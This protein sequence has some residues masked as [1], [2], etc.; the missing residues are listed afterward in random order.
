MAFKSTYTRLGGFYESINHAIHEMDRM[1]RRIIGEDIELETRLSRDLSPVEV[2]VA[3]LEQVIMNLAV[4]ARDAMPRGGKLTIE[5]KNVALDEDYARRHI[6]TVSGSYVMLA[7]SDTGMGMTKEIQAQ[8]FE[9][10]YTTKEKGKGTGLGLSTVYGI[11]KQSRGNIWVYSEPGQGTTFKIYLPVVG[12][13]LSETKNPTKG[14]TKDLFGSEAVL[15]VEDDESLRKLAIKTLEKYGYTVLPA[16]DGREALRLCEE[17][18][19][20]IHLMVTDVIMPGMSGKDLANRLKDMMPDLRVLYMSGY[21]DNA[22]VHHGILEKGI[23]FLQKPFTP[24]GLARKVREA[25]ETGK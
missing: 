7:V 22:I 2:D 16:A 14:E 19:D 10:F 6:A 8:I 3:Q 9:P 20:P 11:V 24:E 4:N 13:I 1:L 18:K 25:L 21:T 15:V 12:M 5:T 17:Y 23:A